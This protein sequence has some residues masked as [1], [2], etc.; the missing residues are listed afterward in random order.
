MNE[1]LD[2]VNIKALTMALSVLSGISLI[3]SL[4]SAENFL[5]I[6]SSSFT[7][8]SA[9]ALALY[10]TKEGRTNYLMVVKMSFG[11]IIADFAFL[12]I[13]DHFP[14]AETICV[15]ITKIAFIIG[16]V[17]MMGSTIFINANTKTKVQQRIINGD[18]I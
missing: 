15:W 7:F 3:L 2:T 10:G 16:A 4:I 17:I 13:T 9:N 18:E 11:A 14:Q 8:F 1:Q 12:L 5:P 6:F